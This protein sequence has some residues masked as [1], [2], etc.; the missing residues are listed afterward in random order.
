MGRAPLATR[1]GGEAASLNAGSSE[2][3]E[4]EMS[5][6][7]SLSR[8]HSRRAFVL[9]AAVALAAAV[10]CGIGATAAASTS[11]T[12]QSFGAAART[13]VGEAARSLMKASPKNTDKPD[14]P[15]RGRGLPG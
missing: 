8:H 6:P 11:Y 14:R 4:C 9:F 12:R 3:G 2:G 15:Q 7:W 13:A 5:F 10:A 1:S